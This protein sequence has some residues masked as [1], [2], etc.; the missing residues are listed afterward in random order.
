MMKG[1]LF[2]A[3][4]SETKLI[5]VQFINQEIVNAMVIRCLLIAEEDL[6]DSFVPVLF[7]SPLH[8]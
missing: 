3:Q 1:N 4:S 5:A 6:F 8:C 7:P 2:S